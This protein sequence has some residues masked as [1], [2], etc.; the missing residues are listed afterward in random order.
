MQRHAHA[1]N[2]VRRQQNENER[3]FRTDSRC[4]RMI[5]SDIRPDARLGLCICVCMH[6]MIARAIYIAISSR[7]MISLLEPG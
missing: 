4:S 7:F 2:D 6:A 3:V 5:L 1:R